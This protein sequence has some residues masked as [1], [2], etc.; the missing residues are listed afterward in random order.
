MKA[1]SWPAGLHPSTHYPGSAAAF[2]FTKAMCI[3][4]I[5]ADAV[6]YRDIC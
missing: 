3:I 6:R 2:R 5:H 1:S 4:V